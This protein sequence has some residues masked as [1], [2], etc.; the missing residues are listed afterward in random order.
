MDELDLG[1]H[2]MIPSAA[3]KWQNLAA[4]AHATLAYAFRDA[5]LHPHTV[6]DYAEATGKAGERSIE[7]H[8]FRIGYASF[9]VA[10][11]DGFPAIVVDMVLD[12]GQSP[13]EARNP[14][15]I[16]ADLRESVSIC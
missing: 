16:T 9:T 5:M 2:R 6:A 3:L 8:W 14:P 11:V 12:D 4:D 15:Q 1:S 13:S 10:L 7:L